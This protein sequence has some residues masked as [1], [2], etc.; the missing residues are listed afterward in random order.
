MA[1]EPKPSIGLDDFIDGYINGRAKLRPNTLRNLQQSRRMLVEHFGKGRAVETITAGDADAF[2][3]SMLAKYSKVTVAREVIRARQF[4]KAAQRR[5]LIQSNPFDDVKGGSQENAARNFF[6]TREMALAVLA[7]CP[8]NE[9]RLI[10]S[11]SRDGGL[12]CPSETL[13]L[14]WSD[15]DWESSRIVIRESKTRA[16]TIPLFAEL[17]PHLEQAFDEAPEGAT[18][19]IRR[20]RGSNCNLRTQFLRILG[21]AG[22]SAWPRLFHNLRASRETE[23]VRE[24]PIHVV[25]KWIGN[26]VKVA[27]KHYLQITDADFEKATSNPTSH[28][29]A[30]G[31]V[32]RQEQQKTAAL[33]AIAENAAV[34]VPST[35]IEPVTFSS[36]G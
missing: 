4:F 26:S 27:Q 1:E 30:S 36:G 32:P 28:T 15:V 8:D 29:H 17:R 13:E 24:F 14:K 18:H 11:L 35:G 25:C 34:Q 31:G 10:F 6:V 5:G 21:R 7:A 23:L 22:V 20:Y 19:V 12:R 33:P 16:R 9:W 2:K 3:E